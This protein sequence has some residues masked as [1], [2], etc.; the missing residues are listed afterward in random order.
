MCILY[1]SVRRWTSGPCPSLC[2]PSDAGLLMEYVRLMELI[3]SPHTDN[4]DILN[5]INN[6]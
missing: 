4:D 1:R 3:R 6:I 2:P 5:I